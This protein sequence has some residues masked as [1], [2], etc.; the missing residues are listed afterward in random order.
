MAW[1]V[2]T[3]TTLALLIGIPV[4]IIAGRLAW[5]GF[6]TSLGIPPDATVPGLS[7]V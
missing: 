6:T 2:T 3:V 4:G 7:L 5:V 1:Q